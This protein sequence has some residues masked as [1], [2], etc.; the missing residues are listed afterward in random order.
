MLAGKHVVLKVD[1]LGCYYGWQNKSVSN[2]KAASILVRAI[3]LISSY[4]ECCIYV[5]HLPRM[6]SWE[7]EM[8][9]RM[10]REKTT[11]KNDEVVLAFYRNFIIPSELVEWL[12]NPVNDWGICSLLLEKVVEKLE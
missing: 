4:L 11:M 5:E 1:N 12:K 2:D 3:H 8:C 6:S 10:S 9:D 7:A